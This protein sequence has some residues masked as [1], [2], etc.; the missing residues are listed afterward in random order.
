MNNSKDKLFAKEV[1]DADFVFDDKV[2]PVFND[3]INRSVPGYATIISM[4]AVFAEKYI[5]R[6][7]NI[8]DLGCSLG[9]ATLAID[10][11]LS[12]Q[13]C[14]IIAVDSSRP[15]IAELE[16]SFA[17]GPGNNRSIELR[18]EDILATDIHDASVV[19]LNFTLQFI[20]VEQRADLLKKIFSG[21]NVGGVLLMSEKIKFPDPSLNALF[22]EM[23]EGFKKSKGYSALEIS[24]KRTALENILV[25]E[26]I[27]THKNRL[28]DIGFD[29]VDVWFQCFNFAS[30]VA[31]KK[32]A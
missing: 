24:Q 17:S 11:Q 16:Q 31:I 1:S 5:Q 15:M 14:R 22:I 29:A 8:Y 27:A 7:S 2:V 3:M 18:C 6:H 12:S 28:K 19:V 32:S 30:L 4:I 9:A 26:S 21:L 25:P 20:P 23:H 10:A 13:S